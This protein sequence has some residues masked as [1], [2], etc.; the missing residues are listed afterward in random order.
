MQEQ[1]P[2]RWGILGSGGIAAKF[3]TSVDAVEDATVIAAASNTPGR[4][5]AFAQTHGI[6]RHYDNY[7][8]LV[9][10]K[11]VDAVY[12]ANTHNF[13][14]ESAM[15]ALSHGKPVLCEKPMA[16]TAAEARQLV[17]LA[18]EKNVFLMEAMWT[19][20]LPAIGQLRDWLAEGRIGAVKQIRAEFGFRVP[21]DPKGRMWNPDLAGGSL[22]DMGIY[23]LS[24]ASMVMGGRA[25][26]SIQSI[27]EPAS[28]G[29]D[30]AVCALLK[31]PGNVLASVASSIST[32]LSGTAQIFG[33]EGDIL[34][35]NLFISTEKVELH[36]R[37]ETIVRCFP[38]PP[39]QG[40]RYEIE[41][42]TRL[43]REGQ[44]ESTIMP[45]DETIRLAEMMDTISAQWKQ[46]EG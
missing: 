39:P 12:V 27:V 36:S 16:V 10:D 29:V 14:F 43:I 7:Q 15:L 9:K 22:L 40:F 11:D 4:A 38:C 20:F 6:P 1:P 2:L 3:T 25:P 26:E 46:S 19:R 35:P 44:K 28:T 21:W 13:H 45:L 24:F 37:N 5:R 32:T 42:A 31:Y 23:P 17:A 30:A 18:R 33:E 41:E 34:V 8:A